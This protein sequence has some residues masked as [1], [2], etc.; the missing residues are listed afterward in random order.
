[1]G[2]GKELE[3]FVADAAKRVE[4]LAPG[5]STKVQLRWDPIKNQGEKVV[6][7][8]VDTKNRVV[9][10]REDNNVASRSLYV[11]KKAILRPAGI[12]FGDQTPEQ[13]RQN[14]MPL[15]ALVRNDGETLAEEVYVTF[16]SEEAQE[17]ENLLGEVLVG[18]IQ[19]GETR[20]ATYLWQIRK[21]DLHKLFR[22]SFQIHLRGSS[23]RI[24]SMELEKPD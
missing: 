24:S 19:P 20:E 13:R 23:Q 8:K 22:P 5:S 15:V 17:K 21:E 18:E 14:T 7:V 9:E 6:F 1:L 16:F 2:K 4:Y 3:N 11:R 12:M 10:A